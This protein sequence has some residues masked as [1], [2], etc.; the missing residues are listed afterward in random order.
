MSQELEI[1]NEQVELNEN[2]EKEFA[3]LRLI[4]KIY[5]PE[6]IYAVHGTYRYDNEKNERELIPETD[7]DGKC[8]LGL[9]S[10][11]GACINNENVLYINPGEILPGAINVDTGCMDG[12]NYDANNDTVIFDHHSEN[13]GN[14]SSA[15]EKVYQTL[16]ELKQINHNETLDRVVD[17]VNKIDNRKYPPEEFL[18]SSKTVLGLQR[19]INFPISYLYFCDHESPNET[20][21][22]E[23]LEEYGLL[24]AAE[25]QQAVIDESIEKLI[26][27]EANQSYFLSDYGRIL[28]N[29]DNE[30]KVGS[31]AAYLK[32][33]GILNITPGKSFALT[34]RD[35]VLDEQKIRNKFGDNFVGKFIRGNMWIYNDSES[36]QLTTWQIIDKLKTNEYLE[37]KELL[38][39]VNEIISHGEFSSLSDLMYEYCDYAECI[40][41]VSEELESF[42]NIQ[43]IIRDFENGQAR[44]CYNNPPTQEDR[45]STIKG[46]LFLF[47]FA[48][49]NRDEAYYLL[50]DCKEYIEKKH[51]YYRELEGD[52]YYEFQEFIDYIQDDEDLEMDGGH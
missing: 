32:F 11:V 36:L 37:R 1:K 43:N 30:L 25:K 27:M 26:E 40:Y 5:N 47:L 6:Q 2:I 51:G 42:N 24:D 17:F 16:I 21:T 9:L 19:N 49:D 7:L 20:L 41:G 46:S 13:S 23:E 31:S 18:N 34:L 38:S 8:A 28:I 52:N 22:T 29:R 48:L 4:E 35:G 44:D 12:F 3:E 15:T 33:E 50:L 14:N 10:L 45:E 39:K